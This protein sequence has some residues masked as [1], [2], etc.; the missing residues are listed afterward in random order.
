MALG[1]KLVGGAAG[2]EEGT[3]DTVE[4]LGSHTWEPGPGGRDQFEK[5]KNENR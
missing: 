1:R 3:F 2:W 4:A 5:P